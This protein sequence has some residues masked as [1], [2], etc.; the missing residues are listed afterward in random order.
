MEVIYAAKDSLKHIKKPVGVGLGTFDGMHIGHMTLVNTLIK[1]SRLLGLSSMIY[2][3][4]QHPDNII[5]KKMS[6]PLLTTVSKKIELLQETS[7][8]YLYFEEFDEDFSK[9]K[10]ESFIKDIIIGKIGAKLVV[11]GFNYTFG[12][13]GTGNVEM[14]RRLGDQY[15]IRTVIIPPVRIDHGIVSS[16]RI[17][18]LV[19]TGE[20]EQVVNL[21]GRYYSITGKVEKGKH[22]GTRLGFPTANIHPED[23]LVLPHFGVYIT[24][25]RIGNAFYPSITNIGVNPTFGE[26]YSVKVETHLLNFDQNLYDEQIEVFFL[27]KIRNEK[28]FRNKE[29]LAKQVSIDIIKARNYFKM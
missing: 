9:I 25:T 6:T 14:L 20:M 27:S 11:A 17:R 16:T 4:A 19:V 18:N 24:K 23:C 13:K 22:L 28:K 7:L 8:D 21:L 3:F 29:E 15:G 2:T 12:H 10:P 5:R 26:N 1:E